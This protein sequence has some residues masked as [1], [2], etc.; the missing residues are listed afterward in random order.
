MNKIRDLKSQRTLSTLHCAI[1][2]DAQERLVPFT[3]SDN[4]T[5]LERGE[6]EGSSF[7]KVTLPNLG[8]ALDAGLVTGQFSCPASFTKKDELPHFCYEV[9]NGIFDRNGVLKS[10]A[11]PLYIKFLRQILLLEGKTWEY[12]TPEQSLRTWRTFKEGQE[13]LRSFSIPTDNEILVSAK[14]ILSHALQRLNLA[15]IEPGHGPGSV[16]ERLDAEERWDF[17]YWP[18]RANK[19]YPYFIYGIPNEL[20]FTPGKMPSRVVKTRVVM[21]P[22]DHRG[23]RLISVEPAVHQYLQQGQMRKIYD[24]VRKHPILSRSI[25]FHDQSKN[26]ERARTAWQDGNFTLDL[27]NASDNVSA[28]L[29]WW[30]LSDLPRLRRQLFATRTEYASYRGETI[31]LSA[32]SPMG[33]AVCFPIES[34]IFWAISMASVKMVLR[35]ET[36]EYL[37]GQVGVFGDDIIAPECAYDAL[38]GTLESLGMVPNLHKTC[39]TTPFRE[40]CGTEYY[41]GQPVSIIRNRKTPYGEIGKQNLP[42]MITLQRSLYS[43]GLYHAADLVAHTIRGVMPVPS[44]TELDESE[45][46]FIVGPYSNEC[47]SFRY[48]KD[49]H[50]HEA[51]TLVFFSRSKKWSHGEMPRL[52]A[53]LFNDN[54]DRVSQRDVIVKSGWRIYPVSG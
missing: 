43:A 8:R 40:S 21:V 51:R 9:F 16:A 14:K 33:S 52:T 4:Q 5:L 12:P 37:S 11:N 15:T 42:D 27:S 23:P 26:Q 7:F 32:F 49:L 31:R 28:T 24:F 41:A 38:F 46:S 44:V 36:L 25:S 6:S 34:L 29:V 18:L 35:S 13:R 2:L 30:I 10:S 48:N 19:V 53:R 45:P 3:K 39:K 47:C 22:K 50:R 54:N 17:S 1:L 20:Y